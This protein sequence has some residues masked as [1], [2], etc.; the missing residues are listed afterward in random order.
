M[1]EPLVS[2][3]IATQNRP[4]L[5]QRALNS[6]LS[7]TYKNLEVIVV[8]DASN[9]DTK[10]V[11]EEFMQKDS[12]IKY[13]KNST[14]MGANFSRNR[15]I[16]EA[17]GEYI[18]G[19]D[20]DD[21]FLPKRIELLM[22]N[23][24]PAYSFITSNNELV[25]DNES[26][27]T[28]M[29]SIITLDHMLYENTAMNQGL[30]KKSRL[31]EAGMFD[32]NLSACQDYDLW[33]RLILKFGDAKALQEVT[34][35]VYME[36][37]RE[38][39][40][41]S[42]K[43]KFKGYFDFYKKYKH[44]MSDEEKKAHFYRIYDTRKKSMSPLVSLVLAKPYEKRSRF[45]RYSIEKA[46]EQQGRANYEFLIDV[47]SRIEKECLGREVI[48]YGFGSVGKF[49]HSV[50]GTKVIAVIEQSVKKKEIRGGIL[51][52]GFDDLEQYG[53]YPIVITPY[54]QR[55]NI[56]E[57]LRAKDVR[58]PLISIYDKL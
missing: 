41:S 58:N 37:S 21:E 4:L 10:T 54:L 31:L 45:E 28:H 39:I 18:A 46:K 24:E 26:R 29:P 42:S 35:K 40:S 49:L 1:S 48:L 5:L 50:M 51:F 3:I 57:E 30:I 17:G 2:V 43:R 19:L 25:F 44:L 33:M 52:I 27:A 16:K 14:V 9:D 32:E 15:G 36:E 34:Q 53:D 38:R 56:V 47:L 7:Q 22:Q 23:Y 6:V 55:E 11:V 13:L 8:D 12:R 20:D